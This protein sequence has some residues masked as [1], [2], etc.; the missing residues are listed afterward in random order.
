MLMR[1]R[2][3]SVL[4]PRNFRRPKLELLYISPTEGKQYKPVGVTLPDGFVLQQ[5]ESK[6][7]DGTEVDEHEGNLI[8]EEG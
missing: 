6:V 7:V 2:W 5:E 3:Q 8:C 1:E 4:N